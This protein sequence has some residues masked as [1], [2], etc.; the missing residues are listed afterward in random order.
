[1]DGCR[2][3]CTVV[4]PNS[5]HAI[6]RKSI[7]TR[8]RPKMPVF[9]MAE[10]RVGRDPQRSVDCNANRRDFLAGQSFVHGV[11]REGRSVTTKDAFVGADPEVAICILGKAIHAC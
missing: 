3:N 4:L 8:V 1:M 11:L 9:E 2:P 10:P 7:R 6:A 5:P